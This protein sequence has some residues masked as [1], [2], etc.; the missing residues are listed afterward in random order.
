LCGFGC[1]SIRRF[2][3]A[4]EWSTDWSDSV[5]LQNS[6]LLPNAVATNPPGLL[7]F[8]TQSDVTR[9]RLFVVYM[10]VYL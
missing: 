5:S 4:N 8:W 1:L 7:P 3:I 6:S 2:L 9:D 10:I